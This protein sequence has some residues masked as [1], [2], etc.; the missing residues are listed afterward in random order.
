MA[1]SELLKALTEITKK[2]Y[3]SKSREY[4]KNNYFNISFTVEVFDF[5]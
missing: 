4:R 2:S 3:G 5:T 1:V